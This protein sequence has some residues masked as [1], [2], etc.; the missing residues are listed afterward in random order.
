MGTLQRYTRI[1]LTELA[2]KGWEFVRLIKQGKGLGKEKTLFRSWLVQ[3]ERL[4]ED[5][6]EVTDRMALEGGIIFFRDFFNDGTAMQMDLIDTLSRMVGAL[7][8]IKDT[9]TFKPMDIAEDIFAREKLKGGYT[10]NIIMSEEKPKTKGYS[11]P[12]NEIRELTSR[13][14][15]ICNMLSQDIE[16]HGSSIVIPGED[17]RP[18]IMSIEA[19]VL[20][21]ISTHAPYFQ[22]RW[23]DAKRKTT[24]EY[25]N[26]I[27]RNLVAEM[28][29][30]LD[31]LEVLEDRMERTEKSQE[32]Q[33]T[34]KAEGLP[35]PPLPSQ[36][37]LEKPTTTSTTKKGP[38]KSGAFYLLLF[39][40][41]MGTIAAIAKIVPFYVLPIIIIGGLLFF[42]VISALQ[43]RQDES[44]SE[45]S[46]LSLIVESLKR[47]HLLK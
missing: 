23:H 2:H 10:K 42:I 15:E 1:D 46:F 35:V 34:C 11:D 33:E 14:R 21:F 30:R 31:L 7:E 39:V 25:D 41:I 29:E 5:S 19:G 18:K 43:L 16:E 32:Q 38:W 4:M 36:S 44:L 27:V 26:I 40:V 28:K 6:I 8:T 45:T 3:I 17:L 13:W 9:Y 37:Q 22:K 20:Q 47:M 12:L 24:D